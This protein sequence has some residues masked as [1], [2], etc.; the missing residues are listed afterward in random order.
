MGSGLYQANFKFPI[1]SFPFL[2]QPGQNIVDRDTGLAYFLKGMSSNV[3][4]EL[5]ERSYDI[6]IGADLLPRLGNFCEKLKPAAACLIVTDS[7]VDPLY[8]TR[9]DDA[10]SSAGFTTSRAVIPAGE[11]SKSQEVLAGLYEDAVEGGLDRQSF[12]VALGGGVV[13]DLAGYLAATFLRGIRFAQVPTSLLAMVD[14]SVGGKTGINLPQGKNLVG[15][16]HQPSLVV[17]DMSALKT[18]PRR[19]YF[20][21]LAE[22]VKYGVIRDAAFFAGLEKNVSKLAGMDEAF[23]EKVIAR[24]CELKAEVVRLDEREG[25]LR[26]ILNFG[27][28]L[29]HAIETV[30]GYGKYLHGEAISMGMVFAAQLSARMG[31]CSPED[32][33]RVAGLLEAL[34]L[35]VRMPDCPWDGILQAMAVDKKNAGRSPRWVLAD[36]LGMAVA[37]CEADGRWLKEIWESLS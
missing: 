31:R 34:E 10:L 24:C 12:V 28:T 30:G 14:S 32:S 13:G 25:G 29:G 37:G 26:A 22:V 36:R 7:N 5:G 1:S 11:T 4:V 19:E 2:R 27:H 33:R 6:C 16:F 8:G 23:L 21:G 18:L 35:P 15:S 3:R 9:V 20:S 17:S